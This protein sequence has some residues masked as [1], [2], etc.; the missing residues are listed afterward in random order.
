MVSISPTRHMHD[1][2]QVHEHVWT[3]TVTCSTHCTCHGTFTTCRAQSCPFLFRRPPSL[4]QG[5]A[6]RVPVYS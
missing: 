4:L 5:I 3:R 6:H 2:Q 1:I